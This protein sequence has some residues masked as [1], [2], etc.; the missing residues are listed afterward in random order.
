MFQYFW[1]TG[2][3][4]CIIIGNFRKEIRE[5][6]K[7][8]AWCVLNNSKAYILSGNGLPPGPE[9]IWIES[10]AKLAEYHLNNNNGTNRIFF[11]P[12]SFEDPSNPGDLFS[13]RHPVIKYE[14]FIKRIN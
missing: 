6:L 7:E 9:I 4:K 3:H 8:K 11:I 13:E 2:V 1:D 12:H 10:S 14:N 5:I